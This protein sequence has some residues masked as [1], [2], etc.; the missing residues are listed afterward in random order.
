MRNSDGK[1]NKKRSI[2]FDDTHFDFDTEMM[3][4]INPTPQKVQTLV[5]DQRRDQNQKPKLNSGIKKRVFSNN[6]N[7][8]QRAGF[9]PKPIN[10]SFQNNFSFGG[11]NQNKNVSFL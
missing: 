4:M 3:K 2:T 7:F 8:N 10:S 6:Q 9:I 1:K 5:I 11:G